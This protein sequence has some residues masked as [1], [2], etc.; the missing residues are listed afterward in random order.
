MKAFNAILATLL[1]FAHCVSAPKTVDVEAAKAKSQAEREMIFKANEIIPGGYFTPYKVGGNGH[2]PDQLSPLF[3]AQY[4]SA[5]AK[6]AYGSGNTFTIV[7]LVFGAAGGGLIGWNIGTA[8]R[9]GDAN[10]GLYIAGGAS[11]VVG[12]IFG[13][14]ADSKY[15]AASRLYNNDLQRALDLAQKTSAIKPQEQF[16]HYMFAYQQSL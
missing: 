2:S 4:A 14:I 3:D 15:T 8:S 5:E 10:S 11:I 7:S 13:V 12:I 6:S 9:G 16:A 1:L